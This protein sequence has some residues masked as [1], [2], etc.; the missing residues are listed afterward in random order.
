AFGRIPSIG[1][2]RTFIGFAAVLALSAAVSGLPRRALLVPAAL[3]ALLALP[4]GVTKPGSGGEK[5][6]FEQETPYHY[7]RVVQVGDERRL[8][9]NEGQAVH[10]LYRP[11]SVLTDGYW[12]AYSVLPFARLDAPPRRMAMLG[13]AGGT[14]ARAYARFYP[15]TAIDGVEIDGEVSAVGRRYFDMHNRHLRVQTEYA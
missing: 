3:G 10:S 9:L 11:G 8:E 13:N 12:D 6:V 5:V 15:G 7:L 4:P 1:T 14:V 2:R